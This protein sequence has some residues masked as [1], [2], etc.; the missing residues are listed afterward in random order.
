MLFGLPKPGILSLGG[1]YMKRH[2][3]AL[4]ALII[5]S[6]VFSFNGLG[7]ARPLGKTINHVKRNNKEFVKLI[8]VL[9]GDAPLIIDK[10]E[11]LRLGFSIE[12][13]FEIYLNGYG[14][15]D[16]KIL[17]RDRLE[18][19]SAEIVDAVNYLFFSAELQLNALSINV[20][21]QYHRYTPPYAIFARTD[22]GWYVL[23]IFYFDNDNTT[24]LEIFRKLGDY[25]EKLERNYW[26]V[27]WYSERG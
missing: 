23:S 27:M 18:E 12:D 25:V 20:G 6:V 10:L 21:P 24:G 1:R 26:L 14:N 16:L 15:D 5:I 13:I 7:C 4:F 17:N 8:P 9:R 22:D 2:K 3:T 11:I 19:F